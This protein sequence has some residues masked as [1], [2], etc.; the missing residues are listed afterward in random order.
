MSKKD[1]V[2]A[3]AAQSPSALDDIFARG[4]LRV[5]VTWMDAP[6]TGAPPE[7]YHDPETGQAKGIGCE[8]GR[9]IAQGLGVEVEFVDMPW[10]EHLDALLDGRVDICP[11]HTNIPD[12]GLMIDFGKALMAFEVICLVEKDSPYQTVEDVNQEDVK[13]ACWTGSSCIEVAE[14]SFPKATIVE[15]A[16]TMQPVQDGTVQACVTDAITKI[17]MEKHPT[18]RPLRNRDGSLMILAREFGK[19]AIRPLDPRFLNWLN[20][21]IDYMWELGPLKELCV[22]WWNGLMVE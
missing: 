11:K 5:A 8:V 22:D 17:A 13:I 1:L 18:L 6:D 20:N 3:I 15:C 4:T 19:P 2:S 12:R 9:M 7:F 14:N 21:W 16:N 10:G